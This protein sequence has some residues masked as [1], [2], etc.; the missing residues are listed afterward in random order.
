MSLCVSESCSAWT[1]NRSLRSLADVM[2]QLSP[3]DHQTPAVNK[4]PRWPVYV[5]FICRSSVT[6][7]SPL[8]PRTIFLVHV[9]PEPPT[10]T[11]RWLPLG[12]KR[13]HKC[14]QARNDGEGEGGDAVEVDMAALKTDM[15]TL[16][17]E[18]GAGVALRVVDEVAETG[19]A[20]ALAVDMRQKKARR[21]QQRQK[22]AVKR[23]RHS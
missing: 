22:R 6:V 3:N 12:L 15:K 11:P 19:T 10:N 8:A 20:Q 18:D 16:E 2:E 9:T 7:I 23:F 13:T 21:Q 17:R 5:S 1:H 4:R 14:L